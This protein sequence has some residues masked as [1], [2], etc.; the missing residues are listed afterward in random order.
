MEAIKVGIIGAMAEEVNWLK[1]Q[2]KDSQTTQIA[3]RDFCEGKLGGTDVVVCECGVGKVNAA[4]VAQTLC[5]RYHVTHLINTGVAGS[6]NNDINIG[7]IV[8]AIDAVHH[9]MDV[10]NLGFK[11]GEVPGLDTVAFPADPELR[12]AALDAVAAVA[13]EIKGFAGRVASGEQFVR[14]QEQKDRIKSLFDAD[15]TEM[16]GAPIAQVA[17][18]NKVPFVVVRAISDKADGSASVDYPTFEKQAAE[19]CAKI[20]EYL[21]AKLTA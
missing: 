3:Q 18:L 13:P 9:D 8:V 4:M 2:L 20:V 16:E 12:A 21:V 15:C 10:C 19:H 5:E 7:D 6:L 14:T 1:A 17:Y 11:P